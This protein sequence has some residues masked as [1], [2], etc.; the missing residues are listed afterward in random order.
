[1][2]PPAPQG[3]TGL[4]R[5]NVHDYLFVKTNTLAKKSMRRSIHYGRNFKKKS[6][7]C[8]AF[9]GCKQLR[10]AS[11]SCNFCCCLCNLDWSMAAMIDFELIDNSKKKG[12]QKWWSY[13]LRSMHVQ[14]KITNVLWSQFCN[15]DHS[16]NGLPF[17]AKQVTPDKKQKFVFSLCYWSLLPN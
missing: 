16:D 13:E 6:K 3:K 5:P 11:L 4:L 10:V 7:K 1:M 8:E 2:A 15:S 12:W 17:K 14:L 9:L